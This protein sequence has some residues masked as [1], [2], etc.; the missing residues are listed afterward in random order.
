MCEPLRVIDVGR[1]GG[2]S[3]NVIETERLI[4]EPLNASRLEDFVALTAQPDA[5]RY[6][7]PGG[8]YTS[9]AA[10]RNF[11]ASLV[12]LSGHGFGRRWVVAKANG[13]GLGFTET[14]YFGRSCDDVS[15]D[16]VEIGWMLT[17]S[18]W[19]QGYATEAGSAVRDEAFD[20][21]GL[22]SIV[23]VHHPENAAS[24]RIMEKLGMAFERDVVARDGWPCRLYRLTREQW[25]S[26]R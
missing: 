7:G 24:G 12:R 26:M 11:A 13:A 21:L 25:A 2:M 22:E 1:N 3:V 16:E 8:P 20:R 23:A 6:W 5:M 18:V 4:L 19:G 9:D 10:E 14:K 15:P 17:P